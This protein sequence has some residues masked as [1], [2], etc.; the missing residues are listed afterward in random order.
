LWVRRV[1]AASDRGGSTGIGVRLRTRVRARP[2]SRDCIDRRFGNS[3]A[4]AFRPDRRGRCRHRLR[5]RQ[6]IGFDAASIPASNAIRVVEKRKGTPRGALSG[7]KVRTSH[8]EWDHPG[9]S[10]ARLRKELSVTYFFAAFFFA[11][12][13]AGFFAAFFATFFLVAI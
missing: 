2:I 9:L 10:R 5:V 13:F 7:P 6:R 11:A 3:P 4:P 1:I 12:F 8:C